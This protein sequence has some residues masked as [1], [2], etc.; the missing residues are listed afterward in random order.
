MAELFRAWCCK[1]FVQARGS[2]NPA[3]VLSIF[4]KFLQFFESFNWILP[5]CANLREH[6]TYSIIEHYF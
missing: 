2:L 1:T 5:V 3:K 6:G 4:F